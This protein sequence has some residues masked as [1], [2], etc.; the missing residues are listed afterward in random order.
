MK[1]VALEELKDRLGDYVRLAHAGEDVL[2]T[3]R[4]E[5]VAE[6]RRA[7]R[8]TLATE[9]EPGLLALAAKGGVLL[10]ARNQAALYPQLARLTAAQSALALLAAERRMAA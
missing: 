10:G 4:G 5:V 3:D 9:V 7:D 8:T 2:L 6:L 1:V